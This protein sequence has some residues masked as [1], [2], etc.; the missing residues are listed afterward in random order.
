MGWSLIKVNTKR[1]GSK[2]VVHTSFRKNGKV[3]SASCG[4]I[5]GIDSLRAERGDGFDA[6]IRSEGDRIYKEWLESGYVSHAFT[7]SETKEREGY[8]EVRSGQ[9]YL[10]RIW[11]DL[12]IGRMLGQ[13]KADGRR[14]YRFD[15]GE[16]AFHL[17]S[18]QLLDSSSKLRAYNDRDEYPFSP[19]GLTLDSLYDSLDVLADNADGIN[20]QTYKRAKKY[21]GKDSTLYFYDVTSVNM[22]KTVGE[23]PLVGMKK[24]KEGIFGPIVQIGYLVDEWGLL[25]GLLVFKGSSSEQPSLREQIARIFGPSKLKDTVICTD[26]GLCSIRNKRYCEVNFKGYITTQPLSRKKVPDFIRE[27]AVDEPFEDGGKAV[28]RKEIIERYGEALKT[29]PEAAKAM[30]GK[31]Y[32]KS[33]WYMTT[34]SVDYLGRETLDGLKEI[35]EGDTGKTTLSRADINSLDKARKG[36]PRKVTFEQRLVVSFNLKYYLSQLADLEAE[37][38]KA[39]AAI[40]SKTDVSGAPR[41]DFKRF[42][43]VRKV[44]EKGEIVEELGV[45]FLQD[46]YDYELSLC[47]VYCQAT[48]LSDGAREIYGSARN[49]WIVEYAFRTAKTSLGMGTVY[50]QTAKHIIGHFELCFLAQMMLRVLTYKL[51]G[52][53]GHGSDKLGKIDPDDESRITQDAVL[54]ELAGMRSSVEKDDKG[55]LCLVAR[56]NKN[57]MN[58]LFAETFRMSLTTQVRKYEDISKFLK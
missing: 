34:T 49:R 37:R 53:I 54:D 56:C 31:T 23:G 43:D 26:A 9:I 50:L 57:D 7:L 28:T 12:G 58:K 42:L 19:E 30:L 27:W 17:A 18:K 55:E 51:Y 52:K 36:K 11:Q 48:N 35:D 44:T 13:I 40:A 33:R 5:K 6:Y 1:D 8:R 25:V 41:R 47:G 22:S 15:L 21:L 32:F 3:S 4:E 38:A 45:S 39:E 14:K 20:L 24:G 10:R 29:D 16:V 46:E 2:Y